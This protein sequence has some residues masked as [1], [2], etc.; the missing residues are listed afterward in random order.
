MTGKVF[1]GISFKKYARKFLIKTLAN[2]LILYSV[3]MIV[4]VFYEPALAETRYWYDQLRGKTYVVVEPAQFKTTEP[5]PQ[6]GLLTDILEGQTVEKLSPVDPQ[7]SLMIPKLAANTRVIENVNSA[8]EK[9]YLDALRYG[10]AHA[11]GTGLP[12]S[13]RHIYLFAHSTNTFANVSRYNAVFYLLYKLEAGDE[14]DI[15]YLGQRYTYTVTGKL[16]VSPTDVSYMTRQTNGEFLT[17]QTC[18]PPGTIAQ[19]LLVFAEPAGQ[20]GEKLSLR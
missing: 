10:V 18:W 6:R 16:I 14:V 7:F 8:D 2:F 5:P 1:E 9:A 17:L 11:A 20:S 13:G 12:G 15:F 19:R 4:W 3:Y